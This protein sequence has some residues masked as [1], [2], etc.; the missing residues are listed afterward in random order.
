MKEKA[1]KPIDNTTSYFL[2]TWYEYNCP[3]CGV[4]ICSCTNDYGERL[5]KT[6]YCS[7]C[8]Q[9]LDWSDVKKNEQGN[10]I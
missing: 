4:K 1:R 9:K 8:G 3:V 7:N 10:D 6:P 2:K 5:N